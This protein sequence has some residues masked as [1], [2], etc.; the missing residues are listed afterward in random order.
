MLFSAEACLCLCRKRQRKTRGRKTTGAK[1]YHASTPALNANRCA[2]SR[3]R[4]NVWTDP[5]ASVEAK[6]L[7]E[8]WDAQ[9]IRALGYTPATAPAKAEL[10]AGGA[11]ALLRR[12]HDL[13]RRSLDYD[14]KEAGTRAP[15]AQAAASC[16]RAR[17]D[18]QEAPS[19]CAEHIHGP[20]EVGRTVIVVHAAAEH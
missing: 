20:R 1:G 6:L 14:Q 4:S 12:V 9:D 8:G 7:E 10:T 3:T 16:P 18:S 13:S 19:A 11:S 2:V 5:P 17:A 15:R